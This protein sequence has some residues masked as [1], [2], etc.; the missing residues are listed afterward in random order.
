MWCFTNAFLQLFGKWKAI[1]LAI[2]GIVGKRIHL[3]D[4]CFHILQPQSGCYN[5][6]TD[7]WF[8][9]RFRFIFC[10]SDGNSV[11]VIVVWYTGVNDELSGLSIDRAYP[12][13]S[14]HSFY[15]K[16]LI[17]TVFFHVFLWHSLFG[18]PLCINA[19]CVL[20][21]VS[22]SVWT[23]VE[24][25]SPRVFVNSLLCW[26]EACLKTDL[27]CFVY[28]DLFKVSVFGFFFEGEVI[29]LKLNLVP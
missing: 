11:T 24:L 17:D 6:V 1:P 8:R 15:P 29:S 13:P 3:Y 19:L 2:V 16:H 18:R 4:G 25:S 12:C 26:V 5:S 23:F 21:S 10:H 28:F 22:F 27:S 14:L 7:W 9:F 20:A